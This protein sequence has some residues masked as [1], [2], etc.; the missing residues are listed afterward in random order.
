VAKADEAER[1]WQVRLP[2]GSMAIPADSRPDNPRASWIYAR[3]TAD[4]F[5]KDLG[6]TVVEVTRQ[7]KAKLLDREIDAVI[8]KPK[9]RPHLRR[10]GKI[11]GAARAAAILDYVALSGDGRAALEV[12]R[13]TADMIEYKK[14]LHRLGVALPASLWVGNARRNDDWFVQ[15]AEP[16]W[17]TDDPDGEDPAAWK[18]IPR[19]EIARILVEDA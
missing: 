5:A 13:A 16:V 12:A 4:M 18:Q 1:I 11:S 15:S 10:L 9:A 7:Q 19:D 14:M 2:D 17:S 8:A 6:G 3:S